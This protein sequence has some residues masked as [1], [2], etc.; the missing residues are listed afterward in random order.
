[1]T[2]DIKLSMKDLRV[3]ISQSRTHKEVEV[4]VPD[5]AQCKVVKNADMLSV[6]QEHRYW[7]LG[8]R[9]H[10]ITDVLKSRSLHVY[11]PED[12]K[13]N[14]IIAGNCSILIEEI[15]AQRV[16]LSTKRSTITVRDCSIEQLSINAIASLATVSG[17]RISHLLQLEMK[18]GAF[19]AK[20]PLADIYK[21]IPRK[22][23][24][25]VSIAQKE[26]VEDSAEPAQH[27]D[28]D[29]HCVGT[30]IKIS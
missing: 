1:M 2:I 3:V 22:N 18:S 5:R 23:I 4:I 8:A 20:T 12:K 27:L 19:T 29:L 30:A 26:N 14:L 15:T 21:V 13:V 7:R 17:T 16:H 25:L 11:V 28:I 6:L 24:G 10:N 9:E